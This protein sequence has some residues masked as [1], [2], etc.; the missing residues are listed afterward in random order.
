[1]CSKMYT[2]S[3][4][5]SQDGLAASAIDSEWNSPGS[6]PGRGNCVVFP[7]KTPKS[8]D[9]RLPFTRGNRLVHSLGKW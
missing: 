2:G 1:M 5:S 8:H 3:L 4:L 6:S 9:G 7:G